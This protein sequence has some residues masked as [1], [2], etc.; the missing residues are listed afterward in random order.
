MDG[1]ETTIHASA[2]L[3]FKARDRKSESPKEISTGSI[4]FGF[5]SSSLTILSAL[6]AYT[7]F[8]KLTSLVDIEFNVPLAKLPLLKKLNPVK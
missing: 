3:F 2:S 1:K 5:V 4:S 6:S 7:L 8:L